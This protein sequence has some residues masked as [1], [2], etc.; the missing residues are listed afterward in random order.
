MS[1][2]PGIEKRTGV[3]SLATGTERYTD[4]DSGHSIKAANNC[5]LPVRKRSA[6]DQASFDGEC[7]R[8][9]LDG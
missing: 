8:R 2:R 9:W 4:D 5:L 3:S 1:P 7:K 6:T